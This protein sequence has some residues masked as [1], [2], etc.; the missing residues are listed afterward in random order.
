MKRCARALPV[1]LLA[2]VAFAAACTPPSTGGPGSTTIPNVRPVAVLD[3]SVTSGNVPLAVDF[4]G[5]GSSD[6]DGSIVSYAWTF[7][8]GATATGPT[9]SITYPAGGVFT[10]TLTVTDNLGATDAASVNIVVN[11]DGDGDGFF[12]PADCNDGD[13][14]IYPGA[15]DAAGDNIDQNCDGIDGVQNDAIFVNS[16]TG[17][18]TSTCGTST[19]PCASIDQ[20]QARAVSLAKANVF[21]AGGSYN[22]FNLQAGLEVRGGYGQNWQRGVQATGSTVATV[23]ASF[24]ASVGAPVGLLADGINVPTRVAD[25]KVVGITA[26]AGQNSY[27]VLVRNSTSALVLDSLAIVGGTA[28][29]GGN[30]APGVAGWGGAAANGGNGG[31]GFEPSG[32]CNTSD[33]GAAGGGGGGANNGGNGG[34]GGAV[35]G[36]CGWTGLCSSCDARPGAAGTAGAGAGAGFGGSSGPAGTSGIP[37]VCNIQGNRATDGGSGGPGAAGNAGAPG[38]AGPAGQAGGTGGLGT[39]GA[40]GGGGGGGGGADCGSD[41]AGAGGG[42]GGAGGAR[43]AS[44]GAG[45]AAGA[46]SIGLRLQNS[47]PVLTGLQI[48]LGKGG[49]GGNGGAGAA[50]QP[51]G[52]GG[53]GGA[54]YERGGAGGSGGAGGLGGASGVGGGGGGGAAIGLSSD[55]A[56]AP[57]GTPTFSGGTGGAGGTGG[58]S[59]ATGSVLNSVVA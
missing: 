4:D 52:A 28:G 25:L 7:G 49:K 27:S 3:A 56:S 24:D 15:P 8:N 51:G 29:D 58:N 20:G 59:G 50:G 42:G 1:V 21:V 39:A 9:A 18:N 22:K 41:D 48:T 23:T 2:V 30:G 37:G 11:G 54:N 26:A 31:N 17:A 40:G 47:S 10:A 43:A 53:A 57:A 45:G 12:P 35:D 14:S 44:G 34:R 33:A 55:A 19:E 5:S 38:A 13:A 16:A 32:L 36:S 6:A 46:A